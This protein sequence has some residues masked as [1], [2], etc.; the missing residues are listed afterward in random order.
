MLSARTVP[1]RVQGRRCRSRGWA[2]GLLE[3]EV[4]AGGAVTLCRTPGGTGWFG[5]VPA[6]GLGGR[7]P[8][9][10]GQCTALWHPATPARML[11]VETRVC[12]LRDEA[13]LLFMFTA[14]WVQLADCAD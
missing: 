13:A 14:S 12:C 6:Q 7:R 4:A 9:V 11:V 1:T 10:G 8:R 3:G 2:L 5:A